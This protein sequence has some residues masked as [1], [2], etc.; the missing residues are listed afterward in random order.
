MNF[1]QLLTLVHEEPLFETGLLLAGV[2]DP[3]DVRR[4]LSRWVNAGRIHQFRR[5]LY[6]LAHPYQKTAPHPFLVANALMPGSYVSTHSALA[7][8]GLIPEYVARTTS[9]TIS[10]PQIWDGGYRFQHIAASL[11]FGYEAVD[12]PHGQK[13]FVATPEKAIL[14]LAHL[15]TASDSPDYL[16]ELRLQNLERLDPERLNEFARRS[17]KPKWLRV[18]KQVETL[19]TEEI[20]GYEELA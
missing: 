5:G 6:M 19:R 16:R 12:L 15:T 8:Y 9:I 17:Q 11:F 3:N 2:N 14:D 4:Q 13:A 10:R 20:E 18:A 7:F 1:E